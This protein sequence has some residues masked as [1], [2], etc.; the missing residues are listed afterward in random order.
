MQADRQVPQSELLTLEMAGRATGWTVGQVVALAERGLI[1]R[2]ARDGRWKLAPAEVAALHALAAA[3]R[4]IGTRP[5]ERLQA[6]VALAAR[7]TVV[8]GHARQV[9]LW[10]SGM[11]TV[12]LGDQAPPHR[13][14]VMVLVDPD[15]LGAAKPSRR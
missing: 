6:R 4:L 2:V 1:E 7:H 14:A 12:D 15:R 10:Q 8:D 11:A 3:E 9:L 13:D 5:G